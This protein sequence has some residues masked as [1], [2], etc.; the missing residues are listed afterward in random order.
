[1]NEHCKYLYIKLLIYSTK[2]ISFVVF[3]SQTNFDVSRAP[4]LNVVPLLYFI[5]GLYAC[6]IATYHLSYPFIEYKCPALYVYIYFFV[7]I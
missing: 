4:K 7:Y 6:N 1:M 3:K 5:D 2:Y